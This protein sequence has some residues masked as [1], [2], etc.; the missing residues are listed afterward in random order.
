MARASFSRPSENEFTGK[1]AAGG[2]INGTDP[3]QFFPGTGRQDASLSIS[4]LTTLGG[5]FQLP[6]NTTPNRFTEGDDIIWTHGSHNIRIGAD[7]ARIDTNTFMPFFQG[8]NWGF[9][10]LSAFLNG[11]VGS[12]QYVPLG[13]YANRDYRELAFTPY[14]QDDWKV[15]SRLTLNLAGCGR[16]ASKYQKHFLRE[17]V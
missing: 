14:A 9:N 12:V 5:A 1:T 10:S 13:A 7:V 15:S 16:I 11:T 8:G 4:G 2:V 3:L 6:F 17:A